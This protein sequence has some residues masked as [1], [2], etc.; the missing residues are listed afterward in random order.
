MQHCY[1]LMAGN[2]PEAD[3]AID[4]MAS[5]LRPKLGLG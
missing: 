1:R 3:A 2:A 4:R 5:W